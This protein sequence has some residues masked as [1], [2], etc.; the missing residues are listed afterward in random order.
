MACSCNVLQELK[1]PIPF[2]HVDSARSTRW[3]WPSRLDPGSCGPGSN[4]EKVGSIQILPPYFQSQAR[5]KHEN[6]KIWDCMTYPGE[7]MRL[8]VRWPW[9]RRTRLQCLSCPCHLLY[10]SQRAVR[11]VPLVTK[12]RSF[13][14]NSLGWKHSSDL[15]R[16][17]MRY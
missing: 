10:H 11:P 9:E 14:T 13:S 3:N 16:I 8:T 2:N 12:R 15:R 5:M 6:L 4:V 17:E 1:I 7:W